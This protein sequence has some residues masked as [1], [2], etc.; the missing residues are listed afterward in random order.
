MTPSIAG[1]SKA[2]PKD[3]VA[4]TFHA[5]TGLPPGSFWKCLL[6]HDFDAGDLRWIITRARVAALVPGDIDKLEKLVMNGLPWLRHIHGPDADAMQRQ[7]KVEPHLL[8]VD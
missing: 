5:C 6:Q 4:I 2:E 1:S 8:P 3:Q 7:L